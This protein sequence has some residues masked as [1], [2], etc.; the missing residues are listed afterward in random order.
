MKKCPSCG[1][2]FDDAMK[3]C[4]VDG[5]P[6]P[7]AEP[8]FDPYATIVSSPASPINPAEESSPGLIDESVAG[9]TSGSVPIGVPQDL[10]DLPQDD[11]MKTMMVSESEM[12]EVLGSGPGD[13]AS[14]AEAMP[15]PPEFISPA[16]ETAPPPS[17]FAAG[18]AEP[19]RTPAF[20]EQATIIQPMADIPFEPPAP[21]AAQEWTPPPA[22][23]A[24]WQDQQIGSNTP[25]QPPAGVGGENR[26]L[27]IVSLV[28][29]ILSI[30]SYVAPI[31]GAAALITGWMAT[32]NIKNNP[33]TY[34]GKGLATAGMI[35]GGIFFLLG[36]A[37]YIYVIFIIG[38]AAMSGGFR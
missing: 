34:G 35:T 22:P 38:F 36:I 9:P 11:P 2:E 13:K 28:L 25:L 24:Q 29:G 1:K 30:C 12:N 19:E 17:P 31:T 7:D 37:Y 16:V 20:E 33:N 32:K 23:N 14:D 27:A 15:T 6:L 18:P 10:L 26:T 21:V 8:A 3:F 5:A 4:Q